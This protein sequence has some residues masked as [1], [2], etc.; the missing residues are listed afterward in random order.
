M[1]HKDFHLN[2]FAS[3]GGI[4]IREIEN[5][6][7]YYTEESSIKSYF[8]AVEV[9]KEEIEGLSE[10][11]EKLYKFMEKEKMVLLKSNFIGTEAFFS[12][13]NNFLGIVAR[14]KVF[15]EEFSEYREV[16]FA[17]ELGHYLDFKWNF[18]FNSNKFIEERNKN[19]EIL[20]EITAWV[21]AKDIL[22]E[23]G[24]NDWDYFD[25]VKFTSLLTYIDDSEDN[26]DVLERIID[27]EEVIVVMR[28]KNHI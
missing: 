15:D 16:A 13:E 12:T 1:K 3:G 28:E 24:F 26:E 19:T 18:E 8:Q 20:S 22:E 23:T 4:I 2:D 21:Y 9:S 6:L 27:N 11:E 25:D 5:K 7:R 14:N 17:H 10:V